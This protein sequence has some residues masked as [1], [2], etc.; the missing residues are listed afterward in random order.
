MPDVRAKYGGVR[1]HAK[2]DLGIID[3]VYKE[4]MDNLKDLGKKTITPKELQTIKTDAYKKVT[5]DRLSQRTEPATDAARKAIA[6]SARKSLEEIDPALK[7]LNKEWGLLKQIEPH[8]E[9]SMN[10]FYNSDLINF[11][12]AAKNGVGS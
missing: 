2:K 7:P 4:I 8:I 1:I 11:G 9:Q 10:R 5:F 3:S 12:G 6:R